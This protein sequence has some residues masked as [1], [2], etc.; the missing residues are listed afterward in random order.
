MPNYAL[1]RAVKRCGWRAV[2]VQRDF[3]LTARWNGLA[4][5]AQRGR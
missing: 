5:P 3:T 2:R 4:W 1:E